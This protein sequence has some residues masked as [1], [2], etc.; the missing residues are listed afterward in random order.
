[1]YR[2]VFRILMIAA[3]AWLAVGC[4]KQISATSDTKFVLGTDVTITLY[5]PGLTAANAEPMLKEA[6]GILAEWDRIACKPGPDNQ[7]AKITQGAGAQSVSVEDAV[8]EMLTKALRLYDASNKA[9][10]IRYGPLLDL[11]GFD[12]TP[13]VPTSAQVDSAK[14]LVSTGGLF[15]AGHSILLAKKGM[16]FDAREIVVGHAFDMAAAKLAE[17]GV[18]TAMIS[19]PRV[20]RTI[21]DPPT[22]RGFPWAVANPLNPK[23]KW[24]TLWVPVG[25]AACAAMSENRF[26]YGGKSYH[27]LLDPRTGYPADK[28]SAAIVQA[29]DAATAQALA[30]AAFVWGGT[31]SLETV[32]KSAVSGAVIVHEQGGVLK[33]SISGSLTDRLDAA[34]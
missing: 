12:K 15:V 18:R 14:A 9:F 33:N 5:D 22:A 26:Q 30:F 27:S 2:S 24:A 11:W 25:G 28:C 32:G 16:R 17:K 6:F 1:M 7:V 20:C 23:M 31:D 3:W 13:R 19:A 8:F 10:D 4:K 29:T 21:G 34:K